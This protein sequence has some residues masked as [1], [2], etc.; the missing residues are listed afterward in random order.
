MSVDVFVGPSL[1]IRRAQRHIAE[2]EECIQAFLR[3]GPYSVQVE[4]DAASGSHLLKVATLHTL[5]EEI[6]LIIGDAAN[7]LRSA[8][9]IL[10]SGYIRSAGGN[11]AAG[12]LPIHETRESL[13]GALQRS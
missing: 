11:I 7:N 4:E 12:N 5:P 13:V 8:L 3:A 1:K 9:D 6:P 10:I 2:L